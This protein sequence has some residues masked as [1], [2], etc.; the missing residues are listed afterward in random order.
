MRDIRN[1]LQ[2]RADIAQ[3]QIKAADV[4]FE[5]MVEKLRH[6][7]DARVADAK[8]VLTVIGKLME[9]ESRF[10]DNVVTLDSQA[11][12]STLADRIKAVGS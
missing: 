8:Q 2:E 12:P 1:D 11:P 5:R 10:A 6:E 3:D 4:Q 7:R 9:F